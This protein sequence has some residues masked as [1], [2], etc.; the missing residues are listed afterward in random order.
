MKVVENAGDSATLK[1]GQVIT[2]RQ[3]R[4]ENSI[5]KR[6]DKVLVEARDVEPATAE[7]VLQGITRASLQPKSSL[8]VKLI[9]ASP[10]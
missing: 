1:E 9:E 5:L 6:E 4:D 3:L 10:R 7:P 8:T 2:P